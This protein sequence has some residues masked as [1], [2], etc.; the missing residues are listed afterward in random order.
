MQHFVEVEES[1]IVKK[2]S[3]D[4][5]D[6]CGKEIIKETYSAFEDDWFS[7][8]LGDSYPDGGFCGTKFTMDLCEEC[9]RKLIEFLKQNGYAI[10]EV[11]E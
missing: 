8:Y 6:K 5:C 3:S 4:T 1:K 11:D 2:Y 10:R 9:T 7:I